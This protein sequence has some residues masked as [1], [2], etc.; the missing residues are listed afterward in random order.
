MPGVTITA[1]TKRC[2]DVVAVEGLTLQVKPGE[3]MAPLG[4]PGTARR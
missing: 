2:N 1:L 4:H 3:P